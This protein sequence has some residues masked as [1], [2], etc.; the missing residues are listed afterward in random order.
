[1]F[2]LLRK[3]PHSLRVIYGLQQKSGKTERGNY[4]T[5]LLRLF[6]NV[7][8]QVL[9]R[10]GGFCNQERYPGTRADDDHSD[11]WMGHTPLLHPLQY[12]IAVHLE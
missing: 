6:Q 7:G 10:R 4:A 3:R 12:R 9:Q 1:M 2:S 5:T 8:R 11:V